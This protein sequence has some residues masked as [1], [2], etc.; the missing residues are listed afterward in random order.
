MATV[1][2][3]IVVVVD[4]IIIVVTV[5]GGLLTILAICTR[6]ALR[7][8]VNVP[9]A[10]LSFGDTLYAAFFSPL[11]IQQILNPHWEPPAALCWLLG[12]STPVLWGVSVTHMLCIAVHRYFIIC[13]NST[14]LKSTRTLVIM[15]LLTWLVPIV[16]FLPI[17]VIEEVKVDPKLKRC[18]VGNSDKIWLKIPPVILIFIV[19]YIVALVFYILIQNHV[20]KSKNRVQANAQGP[21]THLAVGESGGAEP[22]TSKEIVNVTKAFTNLE[23]VERV[24]DE[25]SI[26]SDEREEGNDLIEPDKPKGIS[27]MVTM[28]S[29]TGRQEQGKKSFSSD[30][31]EERKG[32]DLIELDKPKGTTAPGR[33]E[34]TKTYLTS[35]EEQKGNGRTEPGKSKGTT[36]L[37]ATASGTQEKSLSSNEEQ[38][39]NGCNEQGKFKGTMVLAATASGRQEKSLSSD[40]EQKGNDPNESDKGKGTMVMGTSVSGRQETKTFLSSDEEQKG[41]DGNE[42]D[43]GK[44]IIPT[45]NTVL[46]QRHAVQISGS[47]KSAS[48]AERQIT[49]M[50]MMLFAVYTLCTMPI[51]LMVIFSSKVPADAFTV[52]TLLGSLNGALNPIV[53]GAMN[54]NIRREYKCMW[55]SMLN[56]IT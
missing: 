23:G 21:S 18:A 4:G 39:G 53:Y 29:G 26:S 17:H 34:E 49:K 24:G 11:W 47:Q 41:N 3:Y 35:D 45:V 31:V 54:K 16:S 10:S 38:K 42:S 12:Y 8:L 13:T 33:Q 32:N 19:T 20:R 37:A 43:K 9:L 5:V 30:H 36:V 52:G 25:T 22:S 6:P 27:I 50:M 44:V 7:K 15:L 48:A 28:A 14:R 51:I 55:D 46:D 1:G 2:E 40:E 56:F